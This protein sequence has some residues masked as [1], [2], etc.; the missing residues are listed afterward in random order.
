MRIYYR[1]YIYFTFA[2]FAILVLVANACKEGNKES[3]ADFGFDQD[4]MLTI[5][6]ERKFIIGSYHLPKTAT[7]FKTLA[8][9]GYNYVK[10]ND[11]TEIVAAGENGLHVWVYTNSIKTEKR[12]EDEKRISALVNEFK[13]H[14]ALL[15]WEIEDEPAFTWNSAKPRVL[16][17]QMQE[18]YDFIKQVDSEHL[19][20]TNHG[21]VNLIS[22]LQKYNSSTDLVACDVYPV[23]PHGIVPSYALYPDGL[24]GDLL[25]PY[26]SQVGEYVN[27]MKKVVNGSKPVFMVLQGF[28]WEMLKP[29]KDRDTSMVIYPTYEESRFMAYNA[30]VH[31]AN[32]IIYWGTNYTPQ[33]SA[34]M[35]T[36]NKVTRE[37]SEMQDVLAAPDIELNI[38][39]EYHELMYSVDTGVEFITKEVNGNIYFISVNSDKNPVKV[40]FSGLDKYKSVKVLKEN[41]SI[42]INEGQITEN[43]KPFGVH[44]YKLIRA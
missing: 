44:I 2:I 26:I 18:T 6:G 23:V 40:T 28:S 41:R 7:P 8:S 25:N 19:I 42:E 15:F 36:L 10:V 30:I 38:K 33:P 37:L 16:P 43:F 29:E 5:K 17:E 24:Q 9:N 31:G 3:I 20:I 39:K 27:K 32:G 11:A 12:L 14:P 21:P 4:G 13:D 22:T 34:F 35:D 1:F